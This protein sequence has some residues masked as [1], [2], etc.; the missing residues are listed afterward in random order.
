EYDSFGS[1]PADAGLVRR[2]SLRPARAQVRRKR[3]I[4]DFGKSRM[5]TPVPSTV[6]AN[7]WTG[8]AALEGPNID[9]E[10]EW[11]LKGRIFVPRPSTKHLL[12]EATPDA[13]NWSHP[14]VGWGLVL[15]DDDALSDADKA[16]G[17]DVPQLKKL[18]T[19]RKNAPILRYRPGS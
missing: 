9:A 4:P 5:N 11:G 16:V 15:A 12:P 6:Q 14:K 19:A 2:G 3:T 13:R 18:M 7:A 17:E 1:S 8:S 10:E